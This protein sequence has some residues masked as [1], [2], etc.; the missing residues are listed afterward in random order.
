LRS[1]SRAQCSDAVAKDDVDKLL[2]QGR[3][4]ED[5]FGTSDELKPPSTGDRPRV[6]SGLCPHRGRVCIVLKVAIGSM[7]R[8]A[9][10]QAS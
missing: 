8:C 4:L 3:F 1:S 7:T 10:S 2:A 9:P 6:K 5:R